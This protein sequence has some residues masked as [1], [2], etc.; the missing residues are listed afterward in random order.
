MDQRLS[1]VAKY[2]LSLT[3]LTCDFWTANNHRQAADCDRP[4]SAEYKDHLWR[5]NTRRVR[6]RVYTGWQGSALKQTRWQQWNYIPS[7]SDACFSLLNDF[8]KII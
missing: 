3:L 2:R 7:I 1:K 4:A 6:D 8:S 5:C